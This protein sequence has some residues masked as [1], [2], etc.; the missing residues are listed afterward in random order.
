MLPVPVI[1]LPLRSK[2]PPNCGVVSPDISVVTPE[3]TENG[4]DPSNEVAVTTPVILMLPVPVIS[5]PLRSKSPPNCGVVSSRR[6]AIAPD[7]L[8]TTV[9]IPV[10]LPSESTW[11]TAVESASP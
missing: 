2:S 8:M 10:I 9:V 3:T 7:P 11:I 5:L 1:S 4:I 6:L